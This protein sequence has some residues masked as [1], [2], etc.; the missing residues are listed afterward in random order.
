MKRLLTLLMLLPSIAFA[1]QATFTIQG[2][3]D[4]TSPY[5]EGPKLLGCVV[6]VNTGDAL[7]GVIARSADAAVGCERLYRSRRRVLVQ[8]RIQS[9]LTLEADSVVFQ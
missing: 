3:I 7:L 5:Y 9:D 4:A 1:G 8:G 6:Y 2:K